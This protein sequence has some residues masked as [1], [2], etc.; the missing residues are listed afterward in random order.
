MYE[1]GSIRRAA[2]PKW[3]HAASGSS[4]DAYGSAEVDEPKRNRTRVLTRHQLLE[5][6]P[7]TNVLARPRPCRPNTEAPVEEPDHVRVK[8]CARPIECHQED[9]ISDVASDTRKGEEILGRIGDGAAEPCDERPAHFQEAP[10]SVQEPEGSKQFHELSWIGLRQD[11]CI[12]I[13]RDELRVSGRDQVGPRPL[14]QQLGG[15]HLVGILSAAP[16]ERTPVQV[17]PSP[18]A[19]AKPRDV[20]LVDGAHPRFCGSGHSDSLAAAGTGLWEPRRPGCG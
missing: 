1:P 16:R 11:V 7:K 12:R 17:E 8:E 9:R 18:N 13:G 4:R 10:A 2:R 20:C 19:P 3:A 14:Q 5:Q 6:L 15:E